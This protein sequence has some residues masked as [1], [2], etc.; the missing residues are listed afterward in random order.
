[1]SRDANGNY[2][3]P[4]GNPVVSGDTINSS[5]ANDT[6]VDIGTTLTKSLDRFGRG[7]MAA[8]LRLTDGTVTVPSLSFTNSTNTGFYRAGTGDVR[9]SV[10]GVD[11]FKVLE[12]AKLLLEEGVYT[13][14][15]DGL[16]Q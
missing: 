1:M 12:G 15:G 11:A 13:F 3:L 4:T 16:F 14:S 2:T 6:M 10:R 9:L 5:W 8:P 7:G